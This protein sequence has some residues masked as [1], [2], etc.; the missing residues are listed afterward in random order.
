MLPIATPQVPYTENYRIPETQYRTATSCSELEE[1]LFTEYLRGSEEFE[2]DNLLGRSKNIIARVSDS[3]VSKYDFEVMGRSEALKQLN[4]IY[5]LPSNWDSYGSPSLSRELFETALKFV[6]Y[7]KGS[8]LESEPDVVPVSGGG[9]QF[10]WQ[11]GGREL[12]IEFSNK[13]MV[14]YLKVYED[15]SMEEDAFDVEKMSEEFPKLF[16]WLFSKS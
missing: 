10:E 3:S 7:I 6:K 1:G 2:T 14:E 16:S 13:S 4:I 12:E 8:F 11:F 9:V 15:E 5:N